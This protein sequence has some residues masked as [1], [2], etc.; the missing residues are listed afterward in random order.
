MC[1]IASVAMAQ[2]SSGSYE[3]HYLMSVTIDGT[4]NGA[5]VLNT[6]ADAKN[7]YIDRKNVT[8]KVIAGSSIG[9][10]YEAVG[11][12][13][14]N[15]LHS[16]L[17]IDVDGNGFKAT[18]ADIDPATGK[19]SGDLVGYSYLTVG[20]Q[21]YS[22]EGKLTEAAASLKLKN[23]PVPLTGGRFPA[24]LKIDADNVSPNV[25]DA[26]SDDYP[27][28]V[29]DFYIEI[30]TTTVSIEYVYK[31]NGAE[32]AR[33]SHKAVA[34]GDYPA[35]VKSP[36]YGFA[37]KNNSVDGVVEGDATVVV[38]C[39][40]TSD[41]CI[42]YGA[43]AGAVDT[44]YYIQVNGK[45]LKATGAGCA[46]DA[47]RDLSNPDIYSWKFVG[48]R[49]NG[50]SIV[51]KAY[52]SYKLTLS[53]A[54]V[55]TVYENGNGKDNAYRLKSAKGF[56][57]YGAA[58][59]TTD[60]NTANENVVFTEREI[61]VDYPVGYYRIAHGDKYLQSNMTFAGNADAASVFFYSGDDLLSY[62]EGTCLAAKSDNSLYLTV[63][64]DK[65]QFINKGDGVVNIMIG[66]RY[67]HVD[68]SNVKSCISSGHNDNDNHKFVME[69][70]DVL[71]VRISGVNYASFFAAVPV[72]VPAGVTAY[73][74][75]QRNIHETHVVLSEV[76]EGSV[77]PAC[78]GVILYGAE[79]THSFEVASSAT[80]S[81]NNV[82]QGTVEKKNIYSDDYILGL[83][84]G[85]VGLYRTS[86]YLSKGYY[87]NTTH[88][89][90]LPVSAIPAAA[91]KS[92][93]FTFDF[94]GTTAIDEVEG[95][96]SKAVVYDL[97]G[98]C[99][100]NPTSGIYIVNGKKMFV[101]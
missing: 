3:S 31:C 87:T 76:A 47:S 57:S 49:V 2:V 100:E 84:N 88:K 43:T 73:Y 11:S 64:G 4:L 68:G 30:E 52:S 50:F 25:L 10:D 17:Y 85:K 101:K 95:E 53:S 66:S 41:F 56:I 91:T 79:G 34:G 94:E 69:K 82:M 32:I 37:P 21:G 29:I 13:N 7:K 38:D 72:K 44:W 62:S 33:S 70:V 15:N 27:G 54:N 67:M 59:T 8:V 65:I 92:A 86:S 71:P 12:G 28:R 61:S 36:R 51:N 46:A 35:P 5:D 78:F 89:S 55:W 20:S 96:E 39:E 83:S 98:R 23:V 26:N 19:P 90:Y 14:F 48:D 45:Y 97:S 74:I 80:V 1:I 16:Y 99:V 9:V 58:L 24:R 22:H 75:E 60:N 18:N 63:G 81:G 42:E 77:I 93:G 6:G 40:Q